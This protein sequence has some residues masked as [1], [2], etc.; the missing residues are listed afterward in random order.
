[1]TARKA[2][3]PGVGRGNARPADLPDNLVTQTVLG[4]W[5]RV[6]HAA[7]SLA[8]TPTTLYVWCRAGRI[9]NAESLIRLADIIEPKHAGRWRALVRA[10]A[11]LTD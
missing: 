3:K 7:P 9:S 10:L 5:K 2:S 4:R 8:T 1:M 11:G 6:A